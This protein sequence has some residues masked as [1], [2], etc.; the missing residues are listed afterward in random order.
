[1]VLRLKNLNI[2]KRSYRENDLKHIKEDC[3]MQF[4][5]KAFAGHKKKCK[6]TVISENHLK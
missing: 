3:I 1:M 5:K 4:S 6:L 2:D